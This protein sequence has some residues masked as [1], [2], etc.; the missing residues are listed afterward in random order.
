MPV[1][2]FSQK[3]MLQ[4][5]VYAILLKGF[6]VEWQYQVFSEA[7]IQAPQNVEFV[8]DNREVKPRD[9][10]PIVRKRQSAPVNR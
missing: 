8:I 5:L 4:N 9:L 7:A 3:R 10:I 2:V 1:V 6:Y